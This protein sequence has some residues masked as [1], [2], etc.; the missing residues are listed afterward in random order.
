MAAQPADVNPQFDETAVTPIRLAGVVTLRD[1][2]RVAGVSI[3]TASRVLDERLPASKSAAAE[4]VRVAAADLGYVRDPLASAMRRSGTSTIGVIV[5][6]LT[7]TVMAMLYEEIAAAAA[8]R[9]LFA[10]VA[11]TQDRPEAERVAVQSLLHRRVDGIIRATARTGS[12]LRIDGDARPRRWSARAWATSGNRRGRTHS[13]DS[14]KPTATTI[15][16]LPG[17]SCISPR[18]PIRRRPCS[19]SPSPL[20]DCFMP[21]E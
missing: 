20:T 5:P 12:P 21:A 7:D 3:S 14:P 1:V 8:A 17:S 16:T 11:T 15:A 2:A 13:D 9:G 10:V 6:R 18:R 4:R 19:I